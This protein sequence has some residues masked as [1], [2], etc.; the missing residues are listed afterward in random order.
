[1]VNLQPA[2]LADRSLVE[3]FQPAFTRLTSSKQDK[4]LQVNLCLHHWRTGCKETIA[5][6]YHAYTLNEGEE[7][8]LNFG[9]NPGRGVLAVENQKGTYLETLMHN[10]SAQPEVPCCM[11]K[12]PCLPLKGFQGLQ[13]VGLQPKTLADRLLPLKACLPLKAAALKTSL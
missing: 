7:I 6:P 11:P 5:K 9:Q 3:H 13:G 10:Y 2:S 8:L 1:M 4:F 12:H